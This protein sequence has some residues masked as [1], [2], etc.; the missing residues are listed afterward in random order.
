MLEGSFLPIVLVGF[1]HVGSEAPEVQ[2]VL[3]LIVAIATGVFAAGGLV[4]GSPLCARRRFHRP[5]TNRCRRQAAIISAYLPNEESIVLD[6]IATHLRNEPPNHQV[7]VAYNTPTP[8][9]IEAELHTLARHESRLVVLNVGGSR[10]KAEN[11]N[12]AVHVASGEVIGVFDCDH[13]PDAGSYERAWRRLGDGADVV[14]GRCAVRRSETTFLSALVAAEFEQ[15][16]TVGHPGRARAFGFGLFG[17]SN[18]YWRAAA[19]KATRFDPS[20]LTEDID[21][22]MRLLRE[23]GRI[24]QLHLDG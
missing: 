1:S 19:L 8:M 11:I 9:A 24:D 21:A 17:G 6:T 23:G 20:P 15:M 13:H 3:R 18:G 16:Y 7:I 12:A 10:S 4:E 2:S 14:Q 22:S 5:R